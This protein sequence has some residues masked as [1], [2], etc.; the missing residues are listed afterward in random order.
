MMHVGGV[1]EILFLLWVWSKHYNNNNNL[2]NAPPPPPPGTEQE[3]GG[4]S[5][6]RKLTASVFVGLLL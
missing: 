3:N 1:V 4:E 6:L 5:R 2:N